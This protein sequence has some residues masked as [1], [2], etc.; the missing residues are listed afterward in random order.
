MSEASPNKTD[1]WTIKTR[2][3]PEKAGSA[4]VTVSLTNGA[5]GALPEFNVVVDWAAGTEIC[6][7]E[8]HG[9][10][11]VAQSLHFLS[12]DLIRHSLDLKQSGAPSP[13]SRLAP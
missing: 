7:A 3:R 12:Q 10:L 9:A 6:D 11:L 5:L 1:Q 8:A 13:G 2:V 4:T